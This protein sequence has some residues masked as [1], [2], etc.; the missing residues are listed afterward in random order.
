M[1]TKELLQT[2]G[3]AIYETWLKEIDPS[4]ADVIFFSDPVDPPEKFRT[5]KLK[6]VKDNEYPP[7][8]KSFSMLAYFNDHL[9][10]DYDWFVRIDDDTV[11]QWTNLN[12][13]LIRV[14]T[15]MK[16]IKVIT[17]YT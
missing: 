10:N 2:R 1:S 15:D 6:N 8:R 17:I 14:F 5:V 11:V 4:L 9:I 13:F 7:Q 12:E 16:M 3:N